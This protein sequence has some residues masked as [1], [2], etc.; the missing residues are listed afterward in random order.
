[1]R[2]R[3]LF[4]IGVGSTLAIVASF[5][6]ATAQDESAVREAILARFARLHNI[7]VRCTTT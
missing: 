7:I 4:V 1:M 3:R 6:Q 2:I 5:A